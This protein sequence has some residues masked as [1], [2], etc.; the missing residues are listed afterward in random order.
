MPEIIF[1]G[2]AGLLFVWLG[3]RLNAWDF[4]GKTKLQWLGRNSLLLLSLHTVE[5]H[6]FPWNSIADWLDQ[7]SIAPFLVLLLA[8]IALIFSGYCIVRQF[9]RMKKMKHE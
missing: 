4:P 2:G 5:D 7:N 1:A 6:A 8:R 9:Q 3:V